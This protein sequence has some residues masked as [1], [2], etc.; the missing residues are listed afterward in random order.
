MGNI[1]RLNSVLEGSLLATCKTKASI[2]GNILHGKDI[3][4][5]R[6]TLGQKKA[7]PCGSGFIIYILTRS[8]LSAHYYISS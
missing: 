1:H 2:T 6:L 8:T 3:S 5:P 7:W 4:V